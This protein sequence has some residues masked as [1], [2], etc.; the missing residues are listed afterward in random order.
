L[1]GY[2]LAAQMVVIEMV[3]PEDWGTAADFV[4]K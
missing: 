2:V 1:Y 3:V 4:A